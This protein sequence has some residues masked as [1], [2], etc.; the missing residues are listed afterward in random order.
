MIIDSIETDIFD[1][2]TLRKACDN[3]G[4]KSWK[5]VLKEKSLVEQIHKGYN[6]FNPSL[7]K[8]VI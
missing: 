1:T 5:S 7:Y 3:F 4:Y 6:Q 8:K 2:A